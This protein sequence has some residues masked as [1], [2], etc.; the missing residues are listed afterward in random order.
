MNPLH[1]R[2]DKSPKR[3]VKTNHH[4][5]SLYQFPVSETWSILLALTDINTSPT[6][7]SQ[8]GSG[9]HGGD[10]VRSSGNS[11]PDCKQ[12]HRTGQSRRST[13]KISHLSCVEPN[14]QLKERK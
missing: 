9:S 6:H 12:D 8:D 2:G 5:P 4:A 10:T 1:F 13:E 7:S 14:S 3:I 11:H